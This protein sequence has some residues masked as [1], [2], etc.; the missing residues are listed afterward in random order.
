MANKRN[1]T[2]AE[3]AHMEAKRKHY[4]GSKAA[5]VLAL[6]V[7]IQEA[8]AQGH[9]HVLI[10]RAMCRN[11]LIEMC[12]DHFRAVCRDHGLAPGSKSG[13]RKR[14]ARKDRPSK[15]GLR[16]NDKAGAKTPFQRREQEA[17]RVRRPWDPDLEEIYGKDDK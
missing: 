1:R 13:T 7:E 9:S 10:W 17:G 8:F 14:G 15:E 2:V 11:G 16:N 3:M 5:A 12:Y 6:R 4:R